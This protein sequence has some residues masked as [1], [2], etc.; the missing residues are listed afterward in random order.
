MGSKVT[1]NPFLKI[2]QYPDPT[3]EDLFATLAG[4]QAFTKLDLSHAYQQVLL[5]EDSRKFVTITT[6][7]GHCLSP[8]SVPKDHGTHFAR[9]TQ[10]MKRCT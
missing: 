3:A 4:G 5:D 9:H 7:K 6:H 2:A 8:S 1:V 10:G